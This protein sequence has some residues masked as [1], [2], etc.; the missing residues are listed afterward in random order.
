MMSQWAVSAAPALLIV[1]EPPVSI[2]A[3]FAPSTTIAGH[4]D[5]TFWA[6]CERGLVRTVW[7]GGQFGGWGTVR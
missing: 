5:S 7:F 4:A 6:G 2:A 3:S 1:G